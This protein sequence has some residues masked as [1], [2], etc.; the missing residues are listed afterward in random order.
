MHFRYSHTARRFY[1]DFYEM[2]LICSS[3]TFVTTG[4]VVAESKDQQNAHFPVCVNFENGV[5]KV[6]IEGPT[7]ATNVRS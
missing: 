7:W 5:L 6:I 4:R 3:S 1:K 2:Y